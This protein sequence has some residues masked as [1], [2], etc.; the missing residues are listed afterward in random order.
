MFTDRSPIN[1]G[2]QFLGEP[3]SGCTSLERFFLS[4]K[5]TSLGLPRIEYISADSTRIERVEVGLG[6][7][8]E[9]P[10]FVELGGAQRGDDQ[11]PSSGRCLDLLIHSC[12][13]VPQP[14]VGGRRFQG[15]RWPT[16]SPEA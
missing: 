13:A 11:G 14:P 7:Q 10:L 8:P 2:N 1:E 3:K 9:Q 4:S 6:A 16:R 12:P 15:T 5:L